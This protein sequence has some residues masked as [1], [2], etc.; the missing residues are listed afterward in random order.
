MI[1]KCRADAFTLIELLVVISIIALLIAILLPALAS[2]RKAA[3]GVQCLSNLRQFGVASQ[4]YTNDYKGLIRGWT[5]KTSS[6][7]LPWFAAFSPYL[8]GDSA[9]KA[10]ATSVM[11]KME[12]PLVDDA[13][14][15]AVDYGTDTE[16]FCTYAINY[17]LDPNRGNAV[18]APLGRM[19]QISEVLD[20]SRM[21]YLIDG[22]TRFDDTAGQVLSNYPPPSGG[23]PPGVGSTVDW[24]Y[25]I[26]TPHLS[27]T[28]QG[29]FVDGHAQVVP[30]KLDLHWVNPWDH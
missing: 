14:G 13:Y 5:E 9:T 4:V 20:P 7:T 15:Y 2:A 22:W 23:G 12:C 25:R 8:G 16:A 24:M 29:L 27:E 17:Y 6:P 19:T 11:K 30:L 1:G 18:N 21:L 10:S 28:S 3:Q 26:Y